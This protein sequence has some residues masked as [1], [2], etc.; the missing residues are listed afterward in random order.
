MDA[1]SDVG[2]VQHQECD[3]LV[4]ATESVLEGGK[5]RQG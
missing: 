2:D 1:C 4:V 5:G 3:G